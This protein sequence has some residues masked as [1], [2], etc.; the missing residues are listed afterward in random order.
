MRLPIVSTNQHVYKL[1]IISITIQ[2]Q[3]NDIVQNNIEIS[4]QMKIILI[5]VYSSSRYRQI[6][7]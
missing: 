5:D 3:S 1:Y 6:F 7:G 2:S 4:M